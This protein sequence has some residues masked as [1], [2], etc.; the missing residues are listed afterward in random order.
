M[1]DSAAS[2]DLPG[3]IRAYTLNTDFEVKLIDGTVDV[4]SADHA[5]VNDLWQS[6]VRENDRLL[7]DG[8]VLSVLSI[9]PE[10]MIIQ[11]SSYRYYF[12][13]SVQPALFGTCGIRPLACSGILRCQ[14][15]LIVARR[16]KDVFLEPE[17]WELAPSGTMDD[18]AITT[19]GQVDIFGFL[20]REMHEEVGIA[21]ELAKMGK[22]QGVYEH[23]VNHGVDIVIDLFVDYT[24]ADVRTQFETRQTQEY[25]AVEV[26]AETDI[27]S[28]AKDHEKQCVSLTLRLLEH[29]TGP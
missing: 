8:P 3:N 21:P 20:T 26:I 24:A 4:S 28:F 27:L 13:Q 15:G 16:A 2:K 6:A 1:T 11:R 17:C 12:A 22:P 18:A 29:L 19:A 10:K 9:S 7:F 5:T 23:M 25:D 14:D